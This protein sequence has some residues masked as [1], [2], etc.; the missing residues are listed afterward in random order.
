MSTHGQ[1]TLRQARPV[2]VDDGLEDVSCICGLGGKKWPAAS[3]ALSPNRKKYV[4]F[5]A[6]VQS[7]SFFVACFLHSN[8]YVFLHQT[9]RRRLPRTTACLV[10]SVTR[11]WVGAP[12]DRDQ[13]TFHHLFCRSMSVEHWESRRFKVTFG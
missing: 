12:D 5:F 11:R 8:A 9:H 6:V 7:S 2:N 13:L 4:Y 3:Y 10:N 1:P